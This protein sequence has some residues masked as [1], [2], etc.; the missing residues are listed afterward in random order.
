LNKAVAPRRAGISHR[1]KSYLADIM[2]MPRPS[3]LALAIRMAI[4]MQRK[5]Q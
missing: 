2:Q 3:K 4:I 5:K 1:G